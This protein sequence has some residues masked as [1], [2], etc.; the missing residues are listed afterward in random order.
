MAVTIGK[1]MIGG[2]L[3]LALLVPVS[4]AQNNLHSAGNAQFEIVGLHGRSVSYVDE[5]SRHV[6][7][8][9]ERY[10][11]REAL[12][13]P[14]RILVSLKPEDYVDFEGDYVVRAGERGFVNL[15]FRWEE[16][17]SLRRT[18]R[19]LSE[20]LL[21]RYSVFNYGE[22]GPGFLPDW[23][24]A[25]IGTKAY[26]SLR[27]AESKRLSDWLDPEATPDMESL[28]QRKWSDA[29][30]DANGYAFLLAMEQSG[31]ERKWVRGLMAQS[32]SGVNISEALASLIQRGDPVAESLSLNEWWRRSFIQLLAPLE[33]PMETMEVSR[34]WIEA[35]ADLSN[36]EFAELDLSRL[37]DERDNP[38]LRELIQARYE[39]VRLRIVRVNPAYFNAARSL[40]ALFETYLNAEK[41]HKYVHGLTGFLGDFED[42]KELEEAVV[43][44]LQGEKDL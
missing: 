14:Q 29:V 27:P 5:L 30:A 22:D 12:Q 34:V 43:R 9:A 25:A 15:D 7:K 23:P 19:A 39:I 37:W 36:T 41:R 8:V 11:D 42:S 17:L 2:C 33:E 13:F 28:L 38:A 35:L 26:L 20:A 1:L 3:F 6:V 16:P 21:V 24:A 18:C 10:L 40:G 31:L 4:P 44:A 32:L